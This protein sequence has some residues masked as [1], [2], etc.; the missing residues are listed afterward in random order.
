MSLKF[1]T[2]SK[3]ICIDSRQIQE[4]EDPSTYT[5]NFKKIY[6]VVNIELVSAEIPKEVTVEIPESVI[7]F[8]TTDDDGN[9]SDG[10]I[11]IEQGKY[12]AASFVKLFRVK[13]NQQPNSP[14]VITYDPKI[15]KLTIKTNHKKLEVMNQGILGQIIGI[16]QNETIK[17]D[18]VITYLDVTLQQSDLYIFVV[19]ETL[20][21]MES[22]LMTDVFAKVTIDTSSHKYTNIVT[23]NKSYDESSPLSTLSSLLVKL[24]NKTEINVRLLKLFWVTKMYT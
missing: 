15:F 7:N 5:V 11:L 12:T 6:N 2:H 9:I 4:Y 21:S 14:F 22:T 18:E 23:V 19:L 17:T 10:T 1:R 3:I 13:N 24:K 20:G 16:Q 8:R